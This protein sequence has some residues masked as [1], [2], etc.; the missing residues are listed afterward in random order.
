[1]NAAT[2]D[3][4][5]T[6]FAAKQAATVD[7]V[8]ECLQIVTELHHAPHTLDALRAGL[9]TSHEPPT[10]VSLVVRAAQ[11]AGF[12]ARVV[13]IQLTELTDPLLPA[14]VLLKGKK[15]CVVVGV[16]K[17]AN[18]L[19][20][21]YP[22]AGRGETRIELLALDNDYVGACLFAQ[23]QHKFDARTPALPGST[24]PHW[25]GRLLAKSTSIYRDVL[26]AS[27]LLNL[28]ALATPFFIMN[29]Y[30]RVIPNRA[31][32]TLWVLAIGVAVI[33]VFDLL[34]RTL[35]SYL[36]D[37]AGKKT[38]VLASVSIFERVMSLSMADRPASVGGFAN[39]LNAF[40]SV[41]SFITSTTLT[42]LIDLPFVLVFLCA[43]GY[44]A[45]PVVLVPLTVIALALVYC[46][47]IQGPMHRAVE[48]THRSAAQKHATLIES[49]H[50]AEAIKT[51][52]A[53]GAQQR[54]WEE[55]VSHAARWG[56]H[57]RF[58]AASVV[59]V[60]HFL[61]QVSVV[62]VVLAGAYAIDAGTMS[63]GALIATVILT[64]R[65]L[66][67]MSQVASI[68]SSYQ[69][70]RAA[71]TT[72]DALMAK[73]S[74]RDE[75]KEYLQ[76]ERLS[77]AIEF[78]DVSFQYPEH[79]GQVLDGISFTLRAGERVGIIG[80]TGAGKTSISRLLLGL[81]QPSRG[82]IY[83]DGVDQR[84]LDPANLRR[85]IGYVPQQITMFYGSLKDNITMGSATLDPERVLRAANTAG[86]SEF[87]HSHPNGLD[88]AVSENGANLS[89]GQRQSVAIA[90]ALLDEPP[91]F[92]LDEPSSA[93]DSSAEAQLLAKLSAATNNRTLI[94]ITHRASLLSLVDRLIVLD[95]GTI[96]ADGAVADVLEQLNQRPPPGDSSSLT[97]V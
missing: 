38:D 89:G 59:N 8:L 44:L 67:P 62:G 32:E 54:K 61:A 68:A 66:A 35:R 4:V 77:G 21:I 51:L 20:V 24:G 3:L 96:Y 83:F 97:D 65:A 92:V 78:R 22:E 53:E 9:P 43:I 57:L 80:K 94:V 74:E 75:K 72:I 26:A 56:N 13:R 81:Y 30:D 73:P 58:M 28:F 42:T 63:L 87:A 49:L 86:V 90:R 33:Y 60:T 12:S 52:N 47:V 76:R 84:Q 36:I 41:R 64:G 69:Q 34:V 25:F 7:P 29:V 82:A 79:E 31:T 19:R 40:E 91:I 14:I 17:T 11:R 55:A 95:K 93:L 37:F 88:L 85:N 23:P 10:P 39:N 2:E 15:A 50:T 6:R 46:L 70:S 18:A 45:G 1:M 5:A 48:N 71:L 27:F 16:D